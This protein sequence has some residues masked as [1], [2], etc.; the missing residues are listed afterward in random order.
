MKSAKNV[1]YISIL[2]EDYI[3]GLEV[4]G[5]D[6]LSKD[7]FDR[8]S[9]NLSEEEKNLKAKLDQAESPITGSEQK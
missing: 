9:N 3:Q 1:E 2:L 4:D 5:V 6:H 7:S 8:V